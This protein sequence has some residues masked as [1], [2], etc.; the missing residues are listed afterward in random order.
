[1]LS[2]ALTKLV[3]VGNLAQGMTSMQEGMTSMQQQLQ[4]SR[5]VEEHVRENESLRLHIAT[6]ESTYDV[7][8]AQRYAATAVASTPDDGGSHN[9]PGGVMCGTICN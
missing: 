3:T 6:L 4:K 9:T 2:H 1:M 5:G 8:Q 7:P